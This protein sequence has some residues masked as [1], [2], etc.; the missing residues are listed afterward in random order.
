MSSAL[1]TGVRVREVLPEDGRQLASCP[2][3]LSGAERMRVGVLCEAVDTS[4]QRTSRSSSR[5][6]ITSLGGI[7]IRRGSA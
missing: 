3:L 2:R 6:A 7:D 5:I 4:T 1:H